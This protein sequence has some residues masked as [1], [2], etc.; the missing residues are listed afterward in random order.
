ML[1]SLMMMACAHAQ[2]DPFQRMAKIVVRKTVNPAFHLIHAK[3][4]RMASLTLQAHVVS[5]QRLLKT[6]P[7]VKIRGRTRAIFPVPKNL[8]LCLNALSVLLPM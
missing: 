1:S 3:N 4:A 7:N 5:A 2:T 6:A 8:V